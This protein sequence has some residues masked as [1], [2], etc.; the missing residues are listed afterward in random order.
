MSP[1]LKGVA[2]DELRYFTQLRTTDAIDVRSAS[3]L[4]MLIAIAAFGSL[5][6][7]CWKGSAASRKASV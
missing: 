6:T 4:Y 5:V 2:L 1:R 7:C 3:H